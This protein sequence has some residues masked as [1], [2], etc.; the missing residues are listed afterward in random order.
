MSQKSSFIVH[1]NIRKSTRKLTDAEM[2]RLFRAMLDYAEYGALPDFS[3]NDRLEMS[4]DFIQ[5]GIDIDRQKWEETC[6]KRAA[7]GKK[8]GEAKAA[9][10][11]NDLAT[12]TSATDGQKPQANLANARSS[13]KSKQ[14]V[15]NVADIDIENDIEIEIDTV[16]ENEIETEIDSVQE[17]E[18][19]K[20]RGA[21]G[22]HPGKPQLAVTPAV[23]L[24]T[25][26]N[27]LQTKELPAA[28][29]QHRLRLLA[30]LK[31]SQ[32]RAAVQ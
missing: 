10:A 20:E 28:E 7:A 22:N 12:V 23:T 3:D 24:P 8:G 9:H 32:Y 4:F 19:D 31:S 29:R 15:A 1:F 5:P 21:G 16:I 17:V 11:A 6:K 13:G 2:G 25:N 26:T 18:K 30:D 14:K 27:Y